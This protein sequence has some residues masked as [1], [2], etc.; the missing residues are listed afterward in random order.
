VMGVWAV[1]VLA[2]WQGL[3]TLFKRAGWFAGLGVAVIALALTFGFAFNDYFNVWAKSDE[4]YTAFETD[5]TDLAAYLRDKPADRSTLVASELLNYPT[6]V[7]LAPNTLN[8]AWANIGQAIIVPEK[9]LDF[10]I[11]VPVRARAYT[12]LSDGWYKPLG[13]TPKIEKIVSPQGRDLGERYS[14]KLASNFADTLPMTRLTCH[15]NFN[16]EVRLIGYRLNNELKAGQDLSLTLYW[17]AQKTGKANYQ[18]FVHLLDNADSDRKWGQQDANGAYSQGWQKG[19][20]IIGQYNFQV[21]A[22]VK[23][24]VDYLLSIGLYYVD[25]RR[26]DRVPFKGD[27]PSNTAK[28]SLII[29][30][31]RTK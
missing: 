27:C 10:S 14:F 22:E 24:G 20:M 13:A 8:Y 15:A 16:D 12:D 17:Q 23:T 2:I 7:Y 18:I 1:G 4:L 28:T 31:I 5:Y 19:D 9:A 30:G 25:D 26:Q 11:I 21:S 6:I 3:I 29:S